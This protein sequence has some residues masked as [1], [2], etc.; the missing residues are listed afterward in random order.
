MNSLFGMLIG[1]CIV[2]FIGIVRSSR[3]YHDLERR[4]TIKDSYD[5]SIVTFKSTSE[6]RPQNRNAKLIYASQSPIKSFRKVSIV[7]ICFVTIMVGLAISVAGFDSF[8]FLIAAGVGTL[9]VFSPILAGSAYNASIARHAISSKKPYLELHEEGIICH[10][11]LCGPVQEILWIDIIKF[12]PVFPAIGTAYSIQMEHR[13]RG[14]TKIVE[15]RYM[16]NIVD[17][18]LA[19]LVSLLEYYSGLNMRLPGSNL[20]HV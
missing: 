15:S 19:Q 13:V 6:E 2:F 7:T 12:T 1:T 10:S 5:A 17:I 20:Y 3:E 14:E 16:V 8:G 18:E 11:I 9:L 4:P